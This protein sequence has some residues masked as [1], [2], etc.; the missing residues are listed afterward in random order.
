MTQDTD[1]AHESGGMLGGGGGNRTPVLQGQDPAN[2]AESQG[3]SWKRV[4]T[5]AGPEH[6]SSPGPKRGSGVEG[7]P[8]SGPVLSICAH[9]ATRLCDP[10]FE[11]LRAFC[12]AS[13]WTEREPTETGLYWIFREEGP[14]VGTG[15]R[16]LLVNIAKAPDGKL[17]LIADWGEFL[18]DDGSHGFVWMGPIPVPEPPLAGGARP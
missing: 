14:K 4:G 11:G 8:S 7:R 2:A 13:S 12:R 17:W 10:C 5:D 9:C 6:A 18:L 3:Q 1:N 15:P 16:P